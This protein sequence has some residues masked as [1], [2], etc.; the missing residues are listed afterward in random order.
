MPSDTVIIFV[1]QNSQA[2]FIV[3][4]LETF[5]GDANVVLSVDWTLLDSFIVIGLRLSLP[6]NIIGLTIETHHLFVSTYS[7]VLLQNASAEGW[8]VAGIL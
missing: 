6:D 5:N 3:K 8:L 1:V 4:L 2:G 7:P